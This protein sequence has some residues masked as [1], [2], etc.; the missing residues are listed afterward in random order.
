MDIYQI[1]SDLNTKQV[2]DVIT[3]LYK[4]AKEENIG[5][6]GSKDLELLKT[7]NDDSKVEFYRS[8]LF[9]IVEQE[10]PL[11]KFIC[12]ELIENSE[13]LE[14]ERKSDNSSRSGIEIID[15]IALAAVIIPLIQTKVTIKKEK[16]G[17]LVEFGYGGENFQKIIATLVKPL[18][19][20]AKNVK[21]LSIGNIDVIN[22]ETTDK[23]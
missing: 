23:K 5:L 15:I 14:Y 4:K 2:V 16:K 20:L 22:D 17:S 10:N 13:E 9:L 12:S 21:K 3:M 19:E 11:S 8:L 6:E 7:L 1:I 18:V